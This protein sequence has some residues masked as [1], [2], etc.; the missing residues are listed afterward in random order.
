V[1]VDIAVDQGGFFA[2]SRPTTHDDP[3]FTVHESGVLLRANMP[4]AVSRTPTFALTNAT[5]PYVSAIA[6]FGWKK[7]ISLDHALAAGLS[8]HGGTV[9]NLQVAK[10]HERESMDR[11]CSSADGPE[12][13]A[14]RRPAIR[15]RWNSGCPCARFERVTR[16]TRSAITR[17][18]CWRRK[19]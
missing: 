6:G 1:L 5:L 18:Y 8:T 3:S 13:F 15:H 2:D 10:A 4:G 12:L 11:T 19:R 17:P 7:A 16:G 9:T 14:R